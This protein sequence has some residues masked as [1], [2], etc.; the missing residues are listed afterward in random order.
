MVVCL[1]SN[2]IVF[3]GLAH[4]IWTYCIFRKFK[5]FQKL[6]D[7]EMRDATANGIDVASKKKL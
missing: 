7:T 1:N 4:N 3:L 6:L 5:G 2:L